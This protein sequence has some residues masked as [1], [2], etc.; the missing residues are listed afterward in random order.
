MDHQ[1]TVIVASDVMPLLLEACP[2]FASQW[3]D[4]VL[5]ENLDEESDGGRL[6]FVDAG[7][8][9]HHLVSLKVDRRTSEFPAVFDVFERLILEGDT[10]VHNLG[11]VGYLEGL[12]MMTVTEAGLNP[13]RDFRPY[14][15]PASERIWASLNRFWGGTA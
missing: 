3:V 13:E 10:Y 8:F 7:A 9:I 1:P 15:Q 14:L 4:K 2:S 12:Q 5:E 11:E 6:F